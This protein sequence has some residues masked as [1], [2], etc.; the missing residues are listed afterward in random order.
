MLPSAAVNKKKVRV[1]PAERICDGRNL[2]RLL[3]SA[4]KAR[5]SPEVKSE[6]PVEVF[7]AK[8]IKFTLKIWIR[9][10]TKKN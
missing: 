1:P 5:L 10:N 8:V 2:G 9:L 3:I 6:L 7:F 4:P